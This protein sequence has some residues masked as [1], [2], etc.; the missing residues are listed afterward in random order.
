MLSASELEMALTVRRYRTQP[1]EGMP[2]GKN[3]FPLKFESW[4]TR[5]NTCRGWGVGVRKAVG[6]CQGPPWARGREGPRLNCSCPG[7]LTAPL[8]CWERPLSG[9]ISPPGTMRGA[10][11]LLS[12]LVGI[13]DHLQLAGHLQE[14]EKPAPGSVLLSQLLK[15]AG[16]RAWAL[17]RQKPVQWEALELHGKPSV[18]KINNKQIIKKQNQKL[19]FKLRTAW[20]L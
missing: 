7:T 2:P 1:G 3:N 19:K 13:G 16:P 12:I 15:P 20:C 4:P 11:T 5:R 8:L 10:T 14:A 17:R 18:A 9:E 6:E